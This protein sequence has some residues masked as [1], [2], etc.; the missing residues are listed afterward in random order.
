MAKLLVK[1]N[2]N[3][4]LS[5][6]P[7][8]TVEHFLKFSDSKHIHA[9]MTNGDWY[10]YVLKCKYANIEQKIIE[11]KGVCVLTE[12]TLRQL[13]STS[14]RLLESS[15]VASAKKGSLQS[16]SEH[17]SK[18][19][20][21]VFFVSIDTIPI[22]LIQG[23]QD[24]SKVIL[25]YMDI[26]YLEI[27]IAIDKKQ[28]ELPVFIY[29]YYK[30]FSIGLCTRKL[31]FKQ[32]GIWILSVF[33]NLSNYSEMYK[34]PDILGFNT[35]GILIANTNTNILIDMS[36]KSRKRISLIKNKYMAR[37]YAYH[38]TVLK[39]ITYNTLQIHHIKTSMLVLEDSIGNIKSESDLEEFYSTYNTLSI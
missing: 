8:F 11:S 23:I 35:E 3:A 28:I 5:K 1:A 33:N 16:T 36:P 20:T 18:Y 21:P 17:T 12:N 39:Y 4:I 13:R 31:D 7:D 38:H 34:L 10:T 9:K 27:L 22:S 30:S 26:M 24:L 6:G 14:I 29:E 25:D 37:A 19:A 32:T 15:L 2:L